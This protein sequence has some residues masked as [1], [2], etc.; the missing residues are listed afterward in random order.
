M[1]RIKLAAVRLFRGAACRPYKSGFLR[2]LQRASPAL[3]YEIAQVLVNNL[4]NV[5]DDM[6]LF[7]PDITQ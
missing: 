7:A 4:L 3:Y 1:E 6:P 5:A 2:R